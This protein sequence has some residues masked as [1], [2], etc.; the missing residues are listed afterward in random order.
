[1]D[2]PQLLD[3]KYQNDLLTFLLHDF[4]FF[5]KTMEHC[6]ALRK[7]DA[8]KFIANAVYLERHGLI[9]DGPSIRFSGTGDCYVGGGE[10]PRITEKG[11]DFILDDGGL[12]AILNVQTVKLHP[13]TIHDLLANAIEASSLTKEQKDN[14]LDQIKSVPADL[15]KDLLSKLVGKGADAA[16]GHMTRITDLLL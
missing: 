10:L 6:E 4:P 5:E 8:E 3:R 14:F 16:L 13:D 7:K 12:G 15:A 9:E 11:I 2:Q 1:M